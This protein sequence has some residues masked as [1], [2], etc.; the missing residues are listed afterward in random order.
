MKNIIHITSVFVTVFCLILFVQGCNHNH[1][2]HEQSTGTTA[3]DAHAA[4]HKPKYNN[5]LAEFPGHKYALE[6]ID[7]E[8]TGLV[9]VFLTDAH[10]E[11][12]AIDATE[13]QLNFIIE[14]A[15]KVFTLIRTE[16]EAGKP[17]TFTL[18]DPELA[19]LICEGWQGNAI[20]SVEIS[21]KPNNAKLIKLGEQGGQH[22]H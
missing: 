20:A 1:S 5:V 22:V 12:I 19:A 10:F 11:S 9:T 14:G 13:V 17:A 7:D 15:P 4:L 21:G 8:T 2:V 18:T 6:I 16:Q 3:D